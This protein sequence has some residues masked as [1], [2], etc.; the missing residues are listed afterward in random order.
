MPQAAGLV[1]PLWDRGLPATRESTKVPR[2]TTAPRPRAVPTR[3]LAAGVA[4][5]ALSAALLAARPGHPLL[6]EDEAETAVVA[7]NLLEQ[8]IPSPAGRGHVVTQT[9]GADSRLLGGRLVW[10][11]HPWL[12]HF[13]AAGSFALLG[14]GTAAVAAVSPGSSTAENFATKS[15]MLSVP[16]RL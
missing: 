15:A 16:V 3:L 12:Q 4:L 13:L 11:W 6:W 7:R 1:Y 10:I 2:M 8:G 14:E 5:V 9:G